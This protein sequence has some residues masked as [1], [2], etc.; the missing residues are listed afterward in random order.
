MAS[1]VCWWASLMRILTPTSTWTRRCRTRRNCASPA[2]PPS[3]W[4]APRPAAGA[5]KAALALPAAHS[6]AHLLSPSL[7]SPRACR[8]VTVIT[9][10]LGSGKTTLIN[11]ILTNKE[12]IKVCVI[13]NEF[14]SVD[15]DTSLVKENMNVAE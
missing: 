8:P 2:W 7:F 12:G 1:S 3:D 6:S 9:G 5:R 15:I 4:R 10:F 11:H 14:G 13:E